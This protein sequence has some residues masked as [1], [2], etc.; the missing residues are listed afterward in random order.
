MQS[1]HYYEDEG[2][3]GEKVPH[4]NMDTHFVYAGASNSRAKD[5]KSSPTKFSI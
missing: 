1:M 3:E 5:A 2:D 4:E